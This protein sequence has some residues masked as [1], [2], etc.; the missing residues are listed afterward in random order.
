MPVGAVARNIF[1]PKNKQAIDTFLTKS[2][3]D[4]EPKAVIILTMKVPCKHRKTDDNNEKK[5]AN[6]QAM[7]GL[8]YFI[9]LLK[10][11]FFS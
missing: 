1:I 10:Y 9:V 6:Y 3:S 7:F 4:E 5:M 8:K 2:S 11:C